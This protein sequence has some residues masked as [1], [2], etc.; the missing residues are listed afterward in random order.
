[1]QELGGRL[2][3]GDPSDLNLGD[4]W[5]AHWPERFEVK[6]WT[7][8]GA[9]IYDEG[10]GEITA[11]GL[12]HSALLEV[13]CEKSSLSVDEIARALLDTSPSEGDLIQVSAGLQHLHS[14]ALARVR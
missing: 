14:M 4:R 3:P 11:L 6:L 9:V 1:M 10:T 2:S 12:A 8:D 5:E 13:L 7:D